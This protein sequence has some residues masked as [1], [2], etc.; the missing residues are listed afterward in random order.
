MSNEEQVQQLHKENRRLQNEN[1]AFERLLRSTDAHYEG[2]QTSVAELAL[3]LETAKEDSAKL[4][5]LL[6]KR[7]EAKK[8]KAEEGV[9]QGGTG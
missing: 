5:E 8:E 4:I 3:S 9:Q 7:R 2:L 6:D 1:E